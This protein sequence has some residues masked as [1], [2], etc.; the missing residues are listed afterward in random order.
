MITDNVYATKK[1]SLKQLHLFFILYEA[2]LFVEVN[3]FPMK[4]IDFSCKHIR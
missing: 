3:L 2:N 4:T 1:N